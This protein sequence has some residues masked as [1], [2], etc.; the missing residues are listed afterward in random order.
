MSTD[1]FGARTPHSPKRYWTWFFR[2]SKPGWKRLCDRWL[3]LHLSV[4]ALLAFIVPVSL[5]SAAQ[6]VLLPLAGV[7]VGMSFAWVGNALAIAQSPEIDRLAEN[8]PAGFEVYVHTFQTAILVL[9]ASVV[10]WGIAGLGVFDQ[11][12]PWNCSAAG[13]RTVSTIFYALSSLALRECWHV[14]M[15]AQLLLLYQRAVRRESDS[16]RQ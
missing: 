11:P 5:T 2:G 3:L 13:Y 1:G 14:V 4:G 15:G 10:S 12:C 8:N 7:L 9:L 6:T 16:S